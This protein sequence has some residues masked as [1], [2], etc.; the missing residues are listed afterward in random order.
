M[1]CVLRVPQGKGLGGVG[2][3]AMQHTNI[4]QAL[5]MHWHS[6]L[7]SIADEVPMNRCNTCINDPGAGRQQVRYT[8]DHVGQ[9][10][11]SDGY[12]CT[13]ARHIHT[14]YAGYAWPDSS[15]TRFSQSVCTIGQHAWGCADS[16]L[17]SG[18]QQTTCRTAATAL[19]CRALPWLAPSSSCHTLYSH[20]HTPAP[21]ASPSHAGSLACT[22]SSCGLLAS[23]TPCCATRPQVR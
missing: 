22:T 19:H 6:A 12:A 9:P 21:H 3:W 17:P 8:N 11:W 5:G 13:H 10:V 4:G 20:L 23:K 7:T 1:L 14:A 15:C 2:P 18:E 16:Q